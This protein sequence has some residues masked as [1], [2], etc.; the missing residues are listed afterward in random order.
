MREDRLREI[1]AAILSTPAGR[2]WVW[3]VL[4][5]MFVFEERLSVTG[6]DHEAAFWAGQREAGLR[7]LRR[8]ARGSAADFARMF[9]ENDL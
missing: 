8:F 9:H 3:G 7:L 4:N 1:E 5:G 6:S 2:E